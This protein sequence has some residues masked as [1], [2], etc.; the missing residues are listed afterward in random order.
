VGLT[1]FDG[2]PASGVCP[3]PEPANLL[4][5]Y[6]SSCRSVSGNLTGAVLGGARRVALTGAGRNLL[7]VSHA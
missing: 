4:I 5:I 6:L 7:L 3:L 1:R 2:H